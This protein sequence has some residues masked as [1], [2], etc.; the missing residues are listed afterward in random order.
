M[1]T[2]MSEAEAFGILRTRRKQ[3]DAAAAQS[4]QMSGADPEAAVRNASLLADLVLAGC[5][6]GAAPPS[7]AAAVPRG[8]LIAFGDSLVPLLRDVIGEP[9]PHVLARCVKAY[10]RCATAALEAA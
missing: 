9:P 1:S 5:D 6:K 4:L 2:S 3:F 8:Q 10:W 7:D